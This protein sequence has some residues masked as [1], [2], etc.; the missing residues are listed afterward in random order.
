MKLNRSRFTHYLDILSFIILSVVIT[1]YMFIGIARQEHI[2]APSMA[3]IMVYLMNLIFYRL[4]LEFDNTHKSENKYG[5]VYFLSM[6][7]L[8]GILTTI[9]LLVYLVYF[10]SI[11]LHDD[12]VIDMLKNHVFYATIVGCAFSILIAIDN[13][14]TLYRL[15]VK[16]NK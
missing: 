8:L 9:S 10:A 6:L 2:I 12:I 7:Y 1:V 16:E 15:Y 14:N 11:A 4:C 5:K 3:F 13:T